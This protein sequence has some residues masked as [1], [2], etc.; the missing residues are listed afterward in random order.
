MNRPKS[1]TLLA[2]GVLTLAGYY[3]YRVILVAA[4]WDFLIDLFPNSYIPY[5]LALTGVLWGIVGMVIG[6]GLLRGHHWA[7]RITQIVVVIFTLY[8]WFDNLFLASDPAVQTSVL[9]R[10]IATIF[11]LGLI[12]LILARPGAKLYFGA[13]HDR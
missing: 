9:F 5:Y 11:L 4:Q 6:W 3:F 7:P 12:F 1:V 13:L 10:L 8:W 2:V